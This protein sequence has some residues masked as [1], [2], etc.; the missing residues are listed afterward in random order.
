VDL[1]AVDPRA[2][3]LS[4]DWT[5]PYLVSEHWVNVVMA[6]RRKRGLSRR[7]ECPP[8][9][10]AAFETLEA[11]ILNP[12]TGLPD[13][14]VAGDWNGAGL[15]GVFKLQFAYA[16]CGRAYPLALAAARS[17]LAMQ[18]PNGDFCGGGMCMNWDAIWTLR[19]LTDDLRA[20]DDAGAVRAASR[21]LARRLLDAYR[22]PDGAFS[23]TAGSCLPM[24]NSIRVS[25]PRPESDVLGT[26]MALETLH[27][28]DAWE[29]GIP[30]QSM[31]DASIDAGL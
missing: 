5:R 10:K 24:H 20:T 15:G 1:D 13:R 3:T 16:P 4:L 11:E 25:D 12:A 27:I 21:R 7:G 26:V 22:K 14:R 18:E 23:F 17:I 28:T 8:T 9:V 29:T 19:L 6:C 30:S 2:W 31:L